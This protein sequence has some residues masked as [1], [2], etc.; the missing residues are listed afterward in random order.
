[1]F[2]KYGTDNGLDDG[3]I[4]IMEKQEESDNQENKKE[5]IPDHIL[6]LIYKKDALI[7][8][9]QGN[10]L[11]KDKELSSVQ[12]KQLTKYMLYLLTIDNKKLTQNDITSIDNHIR[13]AIF[14]EKE[15]IKKTIEERINMYTQIL[16]NSGKSEKTDEK[17]KILE[18]LNSE[19]NFLPSAILS[20][21]DSNYFT[22][23]LELL[24]S[25][26]YILREKLLQ[27]INTKFLEKPI[28]SY[29]S[30]YIDGVNKLRINVR[31]KPLIISTKTENKIMRKLKKVTFDHWIPYIY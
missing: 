28:G 22:S 20:E 3:K 24:D 4:K 19:L 11:S 12:K 18:Q 13:Y 8:K 10:L 29:P 2:L 21:A 31:R 27:K 17:V 1:M 5:V 6:E 26:K 9:I 23:Q 7:K 25:N 30:S 15:E 16:Q 14:K